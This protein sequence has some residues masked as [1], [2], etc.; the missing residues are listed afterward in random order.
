[1]VCVLGRYSRVLWCFVFWDTYW[2][3]EMVCSVRQTVGL[4]VSILITVYLYTQAITMC[5]RGTGSSVS[6]V[7]FGIHTGFIYRC[8]R[9][10]SCRLCGF[11]T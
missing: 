3:Q 10:T 1:M 5:V 2:V 9:E 11:Y 6:G 8:V 7:F 4:C